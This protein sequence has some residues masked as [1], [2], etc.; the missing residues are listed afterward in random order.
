MA[1][2]YII[3]A[4]GMKGQVM[5]RYS[6][7]IVSKTEHSRSSLR[8]FSARTTATKF[9]R[10]KIRSLGWLRWQQRFS[11]SVPVVIGGG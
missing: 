9:K 4:L 11:L 3:Y 2:N 8:R 1:V 10:Q 7:R 6:F 5:E